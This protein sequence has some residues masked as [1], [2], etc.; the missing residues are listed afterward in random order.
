M[1]KAEKDSAAVFNDVLTHKEKADKI[2][3]SLAVLQRFK[4][5]FHL[6]GRVHR[7]RKRLKFRNNLKQCFLIL[8]KISLFLIRESGDSESFSQVVSDVEKVRSLFKSTNVKVFQ[9]VMNELETAVIEL[10]R[11]LHNQ[12]FD[13]KNMSQQHQIV[14]QLIGTWIKIFKPSKLCL[15]IFCRTRSV[16]RSNVGCS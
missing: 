8:D 6:P 12:L 15:K 11:S 7:C 1:V 5:L 2:R 4:L 14:R 16:R 9:T 13:G 10:Q 3:N